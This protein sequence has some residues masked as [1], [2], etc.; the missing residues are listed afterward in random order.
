LA[1]TTIIRLRADPFQLT[2]GFQ[3]VWRT[4]V[5]GPEAEADHP[6]KATAAQQAAAFRRLW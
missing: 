5:F 1:S 3:H 6:D 2:R 4:Y